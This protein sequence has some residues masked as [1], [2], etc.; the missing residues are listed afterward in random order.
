M[1][2]AVDS[3]ISLE[4]SPTAPEI[5]DYP[6]F[7]LCEPP[8]ESRATRAFRGFIR[9]FSD[10]ETARE[11][12]RAL[13]A[14]LPLQISGGRL[15]V[16]SA[17]TRK[18]PF[19]PY[20]NAMAEPF[21][22]LVLEF[23][24]TEHLRAFIERPRMVCRFSLCPHVRT[25]KSVRI[26][27]LNQ[28]ALCVY[29]G[30]IFRYQTDRGRL[31]QFLD[32]TATYLAKY[33]IWLR[34]RMLF[35]PLADGRR[36]FVYKRK[37]HEPVTQFDLLHSSQVYWD[38]YWAGPSAPSGPARHLATIMPEDECWCWSGDAYGNCCRPR[39]FAYTKRLR[40]LQ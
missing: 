34:T 36:Q 27:G 37:P 20:L 35:R 7:A 24:G 14:D 4:P 28:P 39:E 16:E 23:W 2:A 9:P 21:T 8:V 31:E 5:S 18:H 13:E 26:D 29:S 3:L 32:Q 12:L 30:S 40:R 19:E 22:I 33:L 15:S 25:D 1:A 10:D 11:V 6:Q 17:L 38:G